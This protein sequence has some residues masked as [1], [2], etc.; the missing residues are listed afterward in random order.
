[1]YR[2]KYLGGLGAGTTALVAGCSGVLSDSNTPDHLVT[3]ANSRET[4]NDVFVE[5]D[6]D[7]EETEYGPRTIET[8]D[9]WDVRHI[10]STGELTVRFY[11]DDELIWDDT[12]EI[13]TPGGDRG[14]VTQ[15]A[16]LPNDE[17]RTEVT[18]ED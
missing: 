1:M 15:V 6:F 18:Q 9:I 10:E 3:I 11:V 8:G 17:V 13:P 5:M 14:S 4:P 12:H 16:L 2:R 7:G